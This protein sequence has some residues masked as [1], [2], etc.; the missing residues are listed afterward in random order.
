[1]INALSVEDLVIG[2]NHVSKNNE[3]PMKDLIIQ[4]QIMKMIRPIKDSETENY[5]EIEEN[6]ENTDSENHKFDEMIIK[7]CKLI[8]KRLNLIKY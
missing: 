3:S 8:K 1:M 7:I 5:G 4:N 2:Q 6:D